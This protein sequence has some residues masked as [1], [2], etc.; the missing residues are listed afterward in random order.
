MIFTSPR[1][2]HRYA[3]SCASCDI[4][5]QDM[6]VHLSVRIFHLVLTVRS[7]GSIL[8]IAQGE[9]FAYWQGARR[10]G[11]WGYLG[12]NSSPGQ[13]AG[14]LRG[15]RAVFGRT[16]YTNAH[17]DPPHQN[18]NNVYNKTSEISGEIR[19]RAL[20]LLFAEPASWPGSRIAFSHRY[21]ERVI[22][23][24]WKTAATF[25]NPFGTRQ[26]PWSVAQFLT[27]A[28]FLFTGSAYAS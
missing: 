26:L 13:T 21:S 18:V 6:V 19:L 24:S 14:R 25:S 10:P 28:N 9:Q 20:A 17:P 11:T 16:G 12:S 2:T 15:V 3:I 5:P 4:G 27:F 22:G 1:I 8:T 23:R 7:E